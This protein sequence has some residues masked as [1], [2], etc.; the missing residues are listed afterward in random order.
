MAFTDDSRLDTSGVERTSGGGGGRG[1]AVGG[2]IGGVVLML[3]VGA[4]F[5]QDGINVLNQVTGGSDYSFENV[6]EADGGQEQLQA[7][8]KTGADANSNADCNMVGTKNS[9]DEFWS[10]YLPEQRNIAYQPPILRLFSQSMDTAC[11]HATSAVGPFYCPADNK[12]YVDTTFF[13]DLQTQLGAEGGQS[14]EQY[15]LAHEFGHHIQ[16]QLGDLKYSQKDP[17]GKDSGAVRVELQA[18]CYAGLWA[19]HASENTDAIV[20]VKPFTQDEVDR[21]V[22]ATQVIGDD[23]IQMTS[24]G[25]TDSSTYT[26][27]TS[28]QRTAWFMA[29]YQSGDINKCNTFESRNLDQP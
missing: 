28:D 18:D 25:R 10:A 27:G 17:Q 2:G 14:A 23:H 29:G 3:V 5:G 20:Q 11:G 1:L 16:E 7:D 15:V 26:H 19:K 22:N 9:L 6:Q 13:N 21:I 12:A 4:L 8:C 24:Q